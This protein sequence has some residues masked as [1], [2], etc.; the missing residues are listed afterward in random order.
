[1]TLTDV[2]MAEE[3]YEVFSRIEEITAQEDKYLAGATKEIRNDL[4][5]IIPENPF[6]EIEVEA[7]PP[8]KFSWVI[9]KKIAA[10]ALP[11]NKENLKFLANQ[12]IDHLITLSAG[13]KPP[14]EE[15]CQLRY[16]EIPIEEFCVPSLEQINKFIGLCKSAEKSGEAIGIHCRQGRSRCGVMLACYLIQ[17]H[18]FLPE[19]A[20][21][22][23]RMMRPGSCDFPEQEEIICKFFD[24]LTK[25]NSSKFG[26][27]S[28]IMDEIIDKAKE[29]NKKIN[30]D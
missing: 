8:L 18:K 20:M 30:T 22:V 27:T 15:C 6:P 23:V 14:T 24:D 3:T 16:S 2:E 21:N 1:M 13:K 29:Y 19:Q 25:D 12:G 10:M 17:F 7:Y 9:P 11:R 5:V 4:T 26:V 28:N